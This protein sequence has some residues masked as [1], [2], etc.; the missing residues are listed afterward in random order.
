MMRRV[1]GESVVQSPIADWPVRMGVSA[2]VVRGIVRSR[3]S[4]IEGMVFRVMVLRRI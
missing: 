3:K 1:P 4:V 2:R